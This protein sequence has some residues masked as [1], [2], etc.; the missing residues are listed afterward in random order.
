VR[1]SGDGIGRFSPRFF[2]KILSGF[3]KELATETKENFPP[4]I[5]S[6]DFFKIFSMD[7]SARILKISAIIRMK[8]YSG[9]YEIKRDKNTSLC[10]PL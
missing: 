4:N 10:L 3:L 9:F 1:G 5:F 2:L 6:K 7:F 8:I